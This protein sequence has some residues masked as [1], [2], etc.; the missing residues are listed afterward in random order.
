MFYSEEEARKIDKEIE[1]IHTSEK[2]ELSL[3]QYNSL[4]CV[5]CCLP[6]IGG[7][8]PK[9][10]SIEETYKLINNDKKKWF[11]ELLNQ[12]IGPNGIK[13]KFSNIH[14]LVSPGI[15]ASHYENSFED[16]GKKEMEKRFKRRR[17]LFITKY[18]PKNARKTLENYMSAIKKEEKYSFKHDINSGFF[19]MFF[20]GDNHV[21]KDHLPECQL[22]ANVGDKKGCLAHPQAPE[23]KGVDGREIAGFFKKTDSCTRANCGWSEEFKYLSDSALKVF[24]KAIEGMSWY[25]YSRHSTA[26]MVAYLRVYD[27]LFE[28]M[29]A[30]GKLENK[31]LDE[32]IKFTNELANNWEFKKPVHF[33]KSTQE[34]WITPKHY[35]SG[36]II[37]KG[38]NT[39][40]LTGSFEE[41]A[42][43]EE[44]EKQYRSS[45]ER[46]NEDWEAYHNLRNNITKQLNYTI[47]ST[48][49]GYKI[50][51]DKKHVVH[52]DLEGNKPKFREEENEFLKRV[53]YDAYE[54][55]QLEAGKDK[56]ITSLN[57]AVYKWEN[58]KHVDEY[59]LDI[60]I[61]EKL[62]YI[63]LNTNLSKHYK[64]QLP[65]LRENIEKRIEQ[66]I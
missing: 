14:P 63:G 10:I 9:G 40:I 28:Q 59:S 56:I 61:K 52:I 65:I 2:R 43:S 36:K 11:G 32:L 50:I 4:S 15:V 6:H 3:C 42:K 27:F 17:E 41:C 21:E 13:L 23:S 12:Y 18:N 58:N 22:L 57:D 47:V 39:T 19:T 49:R 30:Q 37:T 53:G 60:P 45:K 8:Y 55:T 29:D 51:F 46:K 24:D 20:G 66:F 62:L 48:T 25:E 33:Y 64:K 54:Q 34:D 38:K 16:V 7:D 26:V 1:I 5:R 35:A 44:M 31:S